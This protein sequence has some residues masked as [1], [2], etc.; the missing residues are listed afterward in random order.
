MMAPAIAFGDSRTAPP[1]T[2]SPF[3]FFDRP[4][5]SIV[6]I[7][8][9]D[10][11]TENMGNFKLFVAGTRHEI[12]AFERLITLLYD[13]RTA[14]A[15]AEPLGM[16]ES[17]EV[18]TAIEGFAAGIGEARPAGPTVEAARAI[19]QAAVHHTSD[20]EIALDDDGA[21]SFDLRLSDGRLVLAELCVN[22]QVHVGVYGENDELKE[23]RTAGYE[24][25]V[26]VIES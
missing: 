10:D 14:T 6:A 15:G 17:A 3:H 21:L 20:P 16:P 22:G 1:Q 26:S 7:G 2:P 9:I 23:H 11:A 12:S 8:E 25:L 5:L 18:K 13:S 19:W 24:F 4:E